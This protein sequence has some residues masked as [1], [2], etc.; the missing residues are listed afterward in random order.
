MAMGYT[1][2]LVVF[3]MP[4]CGYSQCFNA[5]KFSARRAAGVSVNAGLR[6][7]RREA[8]LFRIFCAYVYAQMVTQLV[9]LLSIF[10]H[11]RDI[12]FV[13]VEERL[14]LILVFD[15]CLVHCQELRPAM[16]SP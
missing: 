12:Y 14:L 11:H 7:T 3:Y 13:I 5:A 6:W 4:G 9:Q 8:A 2:S 16:E 10:L 15:L 1:C